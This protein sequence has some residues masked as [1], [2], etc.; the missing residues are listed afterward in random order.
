M[1]RSTHTQQPRWQKF[2]SCRPRVCNA[3]PSYHITCAD[4]C[5]SCNNYGSGV[6]RLQWARVQV[7]QKGPLFPKKTFKKQRRA[8][9]GPP[10]ALG[11]RVLHALHALLLRHWTM[12]M[13]Y[14]VQVVG[15]VVGHWQPTDSLTLLARVACEFLMECGLRSVVCESPH[16]SSGSDDDGEHSSCEIVEKVHVPGASYLHVTFDPRSL[17]CSWSFFSK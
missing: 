4:G 16:A 12:E 14:G 5:H 2:F 17:F 9:F 11:P 10:T 13:W 3:L 8:N 7:F 15:N 1:C 6:T